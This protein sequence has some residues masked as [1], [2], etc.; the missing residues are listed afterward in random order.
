MDQDNKSMHD[1]D[2][3]LICEYYSNF[4]RQGP[5]C[6]E[7]TKKA[8]GFIENLSG[9]SQIADVG[10]GTG[11]QTL[12]LAK[13]TT[14]NIIGIDNSPI[15]I[16]KFNKNVLKDNIQNRVK[17]VVGSMDSLSFKNEELDIILSE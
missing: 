4:E 8:L 10:C 6:P 12:V 11:G 14:G 5:G 16:E 13:N 1:F 17:A 9:L 3:N 2:V 15:M 7:I